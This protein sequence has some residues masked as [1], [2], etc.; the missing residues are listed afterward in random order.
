MSDKPRLL[1]L[2]CCEGGAGYGYWLAGFD[3]TGIDNRP[4]P[5]YTNG[6][7]PFIQADALEYLAEHW[8]EYDAIHASPPC[9][10]YSRLTPPEYRANH[11][12]YIASVRQLLLNTNK[13]YI[14]ENIPDALP[15]LHSPIMLCGSM[16][17]FPLERHRYFELS[18]KL[19]PNWSDKLY[20]RHIK[21][22]VLIS[23]TTRRKTGRFEYNVQE[24]RDASGNY[25][26]TRK[27]LDE[28]IPN[29][30]TRYLGNHLLT[31]VNRQRENV[32]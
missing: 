9:Q 6:C 5:R 16:F 15:L 18:F 31:V 17:D 12:D 14:I 32:W 21:T 7:C 10:R 1:D 4:Q 27:G 13:P 11:P 2:F 3:V 29:I 20:C 26:M 19:M 25:W 23:G 30:Y 28:S 22:P 24:C 8:R